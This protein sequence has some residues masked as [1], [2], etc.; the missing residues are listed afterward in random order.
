MNIIHIVTSL[1]IGG[2]ERFVIDLCELQS[3]YNHNVQ[4]V[5]FGKNDDSLN[6]VCM[7]KNIRVKQINGNFI[8]RNFAILKHILTTDVIH[9][10]SPFALKAILFSLFF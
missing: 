10:H 1:Q 2:A 4:I 3:K 9:I 8:Y 5:S 7:K 6:N